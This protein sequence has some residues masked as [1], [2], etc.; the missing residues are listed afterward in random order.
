MRFRVISP[1]AGALI[2]FSPLA[3]PA[4]AAAETGAPAREANVNASAADAL[5]SAGMK[6]DI[7]KIP[8]LRNA[9]T[10]RV[11]VI[12]TMKSQPALPSK[13]VENTN[14]TEQANLLASWK[15][16]YG[17]QL[18]R[19]FGY[20]VNGFSASIPEDKIADLLA[21]PAVSSVKRERIYYPTENFAR[22]LEGVANAEKDYGVDGTGMVVSIIDSGIDPSHRDLTLDNCD[23][24]AIQT[25]NTSGG[26]FTCKVPNGY[27]YADENYEI[28]DATADQHGQHV[29][30]I[31]AANGKEGTANAVR[32]AA[33]TRSFWQ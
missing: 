9:N 11:R 6:A 22:N 12:V 23:A 8:Q 20:L 28:V 17:L 10:E 19:Q 1:I 2:A 26:K 3:A 25:I 15:E 18:D 16:R 5:I 32:G 33:R 27:N 4:A 24:A 14:K 7:A 30:G 13:S 29:A 21:E 31:V